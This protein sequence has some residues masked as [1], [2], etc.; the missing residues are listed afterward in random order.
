M[1]MKITNVFRAYNVYKTDGSSNSGRISRADENKDM[2]ALSSQAKD[3]H[4]IKQA[5]SKVPDIRHE[6]VEPIKSDISKGIYNVSANKI[7]EKLLGKKN[8]DNNL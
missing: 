3:F 2:V 5:L 1:T 7:A 6:V 8:S 4:S